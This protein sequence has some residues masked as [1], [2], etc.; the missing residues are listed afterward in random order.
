MGSHRGSCQWRGSDDSAASPSSNFHGPFHLLPSVSR[1]RLRQQRPGGKCTGLAERRA[2]LPCGVPT[3]I[4]APS[5]RRRVQEAGL[6]HALG[7]LCKDCWGC[8]HPGS[9]L[10]TFSEPNQSWRGQM[11]HLDAPHGNPPHTHTHWPTSRSG[12]WS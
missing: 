10:W 6:S 7:G 1:K 12:R 2:P 9:D 8:T 3:L 11:A 5:G 4:S